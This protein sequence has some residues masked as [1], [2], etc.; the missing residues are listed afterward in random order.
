[1]KAV[2]IAL[3]PQQML[4]TSGSGMGVCFTFFV[5]G[6]KVVMPPARIVAQHTPPS[7]CTPKLSN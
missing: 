1:M 2:F 5:P 7:A 4:V 3:P 6:Q